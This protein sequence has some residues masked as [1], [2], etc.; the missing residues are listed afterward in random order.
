MNTNRCKFCNHGFRVGYFLSGK[1]D[2]RRSEETKSSA[3]IPIWI[4]ETVKLKIE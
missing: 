1:V 2:F 3:A 4:M